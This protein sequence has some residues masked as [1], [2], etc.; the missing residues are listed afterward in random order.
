[1]GLSARVWLFAAFGAFIALG[2]GSR[3]ASAAARTIVV[4]AGKKSHGPEGNGIHDYGWSAR[5]IAAAFARSNVAEQVRVVVHLD[6][7]PA[8]QRALKQADT[9]VVISDGRDG[10]LYEEALHLATPQHRRTVAQLLAR[11]AG[12]V[13]IHFSNFAPD[14]LAN[15][16]LAWSGGYFDWQNDQGQRQWY[17]AISTKNTTVELATPRHPVLRGVQP[18]ALKEEFYFNLRFRP[19]DRRV[20][21]LWT[22]P[23]LPGRA[24]DGKVVAWA[25]DRGRGRSF[26]TTCGHFYNNWRVPDFRKTILNGIA[27]SAGVTVPPSGVEAPFVERD[28]IAP[29]ASTPADGGAGTD[30]R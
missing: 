6:G 20:T 30:G 17:S 2:A 28:L 1:M 10:D 13:T 8:D 11:G 15:Q 25:V 16:V 12:L 21:P 4:V 29:A 3:A 22:V 19:G 23:A 27:W 9:L 26:A 5:F 18:F 7:W 24:P 14:D